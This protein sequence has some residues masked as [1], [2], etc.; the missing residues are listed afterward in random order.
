MK[1]LFFFLIISCAKPEYLDNQ[2]T[3]DLFQAECSLFFKTEISCLTLKWIDY[4][5]EEKAGS[6]T[7]NAHPENDPRINLELNSE[8]YVDLWMPSHGHGS[9][10]I[11]IT[12][13]KDGSYL[14]SD[15]YFIMPGL[16][17]IRFSLRQE[18]RDVETHSH[19]IQF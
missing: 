17:Q 9:S 14:I 4:P 7:I 13:N 3:T 19:L 10:P 18:G 1:W 6:F 2:K 16:W 8:L 15:V 5:T 11:S 12:K